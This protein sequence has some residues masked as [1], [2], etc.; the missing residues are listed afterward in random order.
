[1]LQKMLGEMLPE[2]PLDHLSF[3]AGGIYGGGLTSYS[4]VLFINGF[5]WQLNHRQMDKM[6]KKGGNAEAILGITVDIGDGRKG[7]IVV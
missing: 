2:P 7:E 1:M 4:N 6:N 5:E 3:L